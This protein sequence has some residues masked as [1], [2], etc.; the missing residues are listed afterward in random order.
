MGVERLI[1]VKTGIKASLC[2]LNK[3]R[4]HSVC[5]ASEIEI[6]FEKVRTSQGQIGLPGKQVSNGN[7]FS[8]TKSL[9]KKYPRRHIY[10]QLDVIF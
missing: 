6:H 1:W 3:S 7:S 9:K 2:C 4:R 5:L 8:S 10:D